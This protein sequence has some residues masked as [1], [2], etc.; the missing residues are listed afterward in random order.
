VAHAAARLKEAEKLGFARAVG[1]R[2]ASGEAPTGL[3]RA[4]VAQL[5]DLVTRI[6]ADGAGGAAAPRREQRG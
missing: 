2:L 1:P 4:A 6:A 3:K 5:V